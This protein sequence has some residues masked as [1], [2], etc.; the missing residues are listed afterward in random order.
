[1]KLLWLFF[2]LQVVYGKPRFESFYS[3]SS[4]LCHPWSCIN[5][6][7]GLPE[8]LT[9][10]DLAREAFIRVLPQGSWHDV[11]E[12]VLDNCYTNSGRRYVSTCPGQALLHC[13]VDQMIN[14]CPEENWRKDDGCSP[15]SSL[16]GFK[17]MFTVSRYENLQQ[18]LEKE[19]RPKWFLEHY[20]DKKC[21][22][23]PVMFNS[24]VLQECGFNSFITYYDHGLRYQDSQ[25]P[26][27]W[28]S[29]P[30]S[31]P[32]TA[33]GSGDMVQM[34]SLNQTI[35]PGLLTQSPPILPSLQQPS[36]QSSGDRVLMV[37][38]NQTTT[39]RP[40][41]SQSVDP[42]DC[43]D[44]TGFI[45]P[46]WRTECGFHLTWKGPER[47]VITNYTP[48]QTTEAP[49][50]TTTARTDPPKDLMLLPHSCY[51]ETC[52]FKK[53]GVID[54][55]GLIDTTAFRR[56]LDNFT[57]AHPSWKNPTARVFSK[58][59]SRGGR[60][61]ESSCEINK[62]L[63]CT[64]DVLTEN[65]PYK[66]KSED[67]CRHGK[68][69][70]GCQISSSKLRPKNRRQIC[71]LPPLVDLNVLS[72]CGLNSLYKSEHVVIPEPKPKKHFWS[73]S[74][75]LCQDQKP[76]TTCVMK[77]MGILN[78]Y[79][80]MDYFRMKDRIRQFTTNEPVWSALLDIYMGAFINIP[81]YGE[82]CSSQKKMLN[83]I[84]AMLL[85]CPVSKRKDSSQCKQFFKDMTDT[86]PSPNQNF[87]RQ[88]LDE[89]MK[90][91]HHIFLQ[92]SYLPPNVDPVIRKPKPKTV[93]KPIYSYGFLDSEKSP[94]VT[95]INIKPA[96]VTELD[97][98]LVL[99]PV[100]LRNSKLGVAL[101][102]AQDNLYRS[103]RPFWLHDNR[104][105]APFTT[106]VPAISTNTSF[107]TKLESTT[108]EQ[109]T[110]IKEA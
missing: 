34:V 65:C 102:I 93:K 57:E 2:V 37:S 83:V 96:V 107:S 28:R 32:P 17:Q 80:F 78:K 44:M 92:N 3:R 74:R 82:H 30:P 6:K 7:L 71:L 109:T 110:N 35:T 61:Y 50:T 10:Q 16:A 23:L 13:V 77:K 27:A 75:N 55:S 51:Q 39:S 108:I 95:V 98:P 42:L 68:R 79:R 26:P 43:C 12:K 105:R 18:N 36:T 99:A 25:S 1:M 81:M 85:T 49:V 56:M 104:P 63:A 40:L 24:S 46:S 48:K 5:I 97:K 89:M 73:S 41:E 53:V 69:K 52:V 100:Y 47:L 21:C 91:Y 66:R 4:R 22:D 19:H 103:N 76:S 38:L 31:Q 67:P 59:L 64:L 94:K 33:R 14:N 88:K 84:D 20:F 72:E 8:S 86:P 101:P 62:M 58:C 45:Q 60:D 15:V 87:T 29:P 106:P 54:E 11:L 70:G 9:P 90:H